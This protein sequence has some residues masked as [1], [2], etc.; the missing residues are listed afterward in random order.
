VHSTN[1]DNSPNL[2]R[3][4]NLGAYWER[5]FCRLAG[6]CGSVILPQ[7]IGRTGAA[8]VFYRDAETWQQRILPDVTLWTRTG[9]EHHEIKHKAPTRNGGLYG[10]E[11]YR[12]DDLLW[13]SRKS[14]EPVFLTIHNHALSGGRD[15]RVNSIAHWVTARIDDL[16]ERWIMR[17]ISSTWMNGKRATAEVFYWPQWLFRPLAHHLS[18]QVPPR[19]SGGAAAIANVSRLLKLAA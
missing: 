19:P 8:R 7:Q 6:A 16:N 2:D 18:S 3:D 9:C 15:G 5:Q 10:L 14:K 1:L 13:F 11:K 4:R 12:F 17:S